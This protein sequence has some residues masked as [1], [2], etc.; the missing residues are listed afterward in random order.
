VFEPFF[1]TRRGLGG[2]GLGLHLVYNLVTIRLNGSIEV[3]SR[4]GGGTVFS[5]R[6]P[7]VTRAT[8]S[9]ASALR[10]AP[11]SPQ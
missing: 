1:T 10:T 8:S 2:S 4:E 6:L 5:L 3:G 7:R 11:R 9:L